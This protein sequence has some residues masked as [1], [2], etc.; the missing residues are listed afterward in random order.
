MFWVVSKCKQ[1]QIRGNFKKQNL[2]EKLFIRRQQ[3]EKVKKYKYLGARVNED[4]EHGMEVKCWIEMARG[5]FVKMSKE[6]KCHDFS[7]G[8]KIRILRCYTFPILLYGART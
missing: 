6:L 1:N 8:T 4:W 7:L 5:A 3:I 2:R